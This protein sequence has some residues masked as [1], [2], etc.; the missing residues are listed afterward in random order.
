MLKIGYIVGEFVDPAISFGKGLIKLVFVIAV[1]IGIVCV[2][3]AAI[4]YL[5]FN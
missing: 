2:P 1:I 4:K 3:I 5:F